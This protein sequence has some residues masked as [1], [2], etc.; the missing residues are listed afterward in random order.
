MNFKALQYL[1]VYTV[2]VVGFLGFFKFGAWTWA[3][4]IYAYGLV[5]AVEFLSKG[6]KENMSKAE[7]EIAKDS[8]IYDW[9]VYSIVPL[10]WAMFITF[11]F[12]IQTPGLAWWEYTGLI[13]SMGIGCAAFGIN[14]A[15]ELGHRHKWYEQWMAKALLLTAQYMHFFIEHNRGHHKNVSTSE[16]PATS[17]YGEIVYTFWFRSVIMGYISAWKI[18]LEQLKR[19]GKPWYHYSNEMT[20]YAMVQIG[21]L[22]AV[23]MVFNVQVMAAVFAASCIG[24]LLLETV[25]YIEHYGLARHK[26]GDRYQRVL[27]IHSWNSDHPMGRLLLFELSRHSDH[28]YMASRPYQVLRHFDDSPQMPTGY[29]GMI[30]LALVPP[31]WFAVMNPRVDKLRQQYPDDLAVAA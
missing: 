13:V 10:Q 31:L 25:N 6:S 3:V 7:E 8:R 19:Q 17:R 11:M 2:P 29:P 24:F 16:D 28:H 22:V 1:F 15:H 5:P 20:F 23:A 18:E 4:P 12:V 27:P 9:M 30:V 14:V 26:R 21:F